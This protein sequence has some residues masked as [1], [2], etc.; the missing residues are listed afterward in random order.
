M[1]ILFRMPTSAPGRPEFAGVACRPCWN[2]KR[3]TQDY[4]KFEGKAIAKRLEP[5]IP[6]SGAI[7]IHPATVSRLLAHGSRVSQPCMRIILTKQISM[8]AI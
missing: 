3:Q 1:E 7:T 5:L 6:V 2:L 8:K 4:R